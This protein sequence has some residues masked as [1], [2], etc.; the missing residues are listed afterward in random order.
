[1]LSKFYL[2]FIALAF[3]T[4][5]I[6]P[7]F[8]MPVDH[9]N[10]LIGGIVHSILRW[11]KAVLCVRIHVR[12]SSFIVKTILRKYKELLFFFDFLFFLVIRNHVHEALI[13]NY[14]H[15]TIFIY[16]K[17]VIFYNLNL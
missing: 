9:P 13:R 1:M 3:I 17:L 2:I 11:V 16:D 6:N 10:K 7:A 14:M 4:I 12:D 5:I 15:F 8:T